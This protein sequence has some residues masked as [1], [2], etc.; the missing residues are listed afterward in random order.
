M[1]GAGGAEGEGAQ[2]AAWRLGLPLRTVTVLTL[3]DQRHALFLLDSGLTKQHPSA[4]FP[5]HQLR[6]TWKSL[7]LS[8]L[9]FCSEVPGH[10]AWL[11]K[12]EQNDRGE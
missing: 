1:G 2:M 8:A 7:L 3:A 11:V 5:S 10:S 4:C 6:Q 9:G 12:E